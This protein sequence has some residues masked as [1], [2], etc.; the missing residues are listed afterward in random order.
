MTRLCLISIAVLAACVPTPARGVQAAPAPRARAT[1]TYLGVAGFRLESGGA[2]LLFDPYV[3]RLA[4]P[5]FNARV[6]PDLASIARYTPTRADAILISHSHF[7]HVLDA[8]S[9]A[10]RTGAVLLGTDST[11]VLAR[12][13]GVPDA[14]I[15]AAH[16]GEHFKLGA[17]DVRVVPALHSLTGQP[18]LPIA[19]GQALPLRAN[20]YQEGNT[21]QYFVR[22]NGHALYFVGTA[23][24]V[25]AAVRGM[26]PDVAIVATGLRHKLPDYTCRLLRALGFPARVL[27]NHFDAWQ[28][29]LVPGNMPLKPETATDLEAFTAE[30][31]SCAP[32]T[33]VEVPMHLQ[34]IPL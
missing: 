28:E 19:P 31:H 32:Q 5:D 29:P 18:N 9:I 17:F 22:V 4:V 10:L 16:G 8:P 33:R 34:P 6:E 14:Q 30:V 26:H 1:L 13:A 12:S 23:N 20:D 25:D 11:A 27:A 15:I 21:L 2:N 7:D 24:F 3:S